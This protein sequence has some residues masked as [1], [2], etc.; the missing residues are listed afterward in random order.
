MLPEYSDKSEAVV[1]KGFAD[2]LFPCPNYHRP[3]LSLL[4]FSLLPRGR[5]FCVALCLLYLSA[6]FACCSL[7]LSYSSSQ[8]P[9][10]NL[11]ICCNYFPPAIAECTVVCMTALCLEAAGLRREVCLA[12]AFCCAGW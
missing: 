7:S 2:V 1:I 5:E 9:L 8:C 3:G 10:S 11:G 12:Q 4:I 6:T